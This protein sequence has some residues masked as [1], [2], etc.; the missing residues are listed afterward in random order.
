MNNSKIQIILCV[1]FLSLWAAG[2]E[3]IPF[4]CTMPIVLE[5][6]LTSIQSRE[7]PSDTQK[8]SGGTFMEPPEGPPVACVFETRECKPREE[9]M[10][11]DR[12]VEVTFDKPSGHVFRLLVK[13]DLVMRIEHTDPSGEM[14]V[15]YQ[16]LLH[17]LDRLDFK[18]EEYTRLSRESYLKICT[19]ECLWLRLPT[20]R[21]VAEIRLMET[22]AYERQKR[23]FKGRMEFPDKPL[24]VHFS[25]IDG[26]LHHLYV[27]GF[28][29]RDHAMSDPKIV[30]YILNR[31]PS[32]TWLGHCIF[33]ASFLDKWSHSLLHVQFY[34]NMGL[35]EYSKHQL[36]APA[37]IIKWEE[38]GLKRKR[39]TP[40]QQSKMTMKWLKSIGIDPSRK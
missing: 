18:D 29:N 5:P 39:Y 23:I 37:D 38:N 36:L 2:E 22:N 12:I 32:G 40:A 25:F 21:H 34:K 17:W 20:G 4:D 1:M 3:S 24:T 10:E 26:V 8:S 35:R 19:G 13:D 14:R 28:R 31:A 6:V 7:E 33:Q 30:Y 9:E 11:Y 15:Y 16:T 27:F